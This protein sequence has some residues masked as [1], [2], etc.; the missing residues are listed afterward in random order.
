MKKPLLVVLLCFGS[1]PAQELPAAPHARALTMIQLAASTADAVATYRN[2]S[3]C[4]NASTNPRVHCSEVNPISRPF[5]M[6][7][8]PELAAYFV[9]ETSIKLVV[10][11]VL[12]HFG[13]HKWARAIRYW[14]IADNASGA[15]MSFAGHHR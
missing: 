6:E 13:H 9:G 4:Y 5:V 7:G 8:T 12:D 2:D 14:G 3:R 15:T 10:P 1:L 11:F